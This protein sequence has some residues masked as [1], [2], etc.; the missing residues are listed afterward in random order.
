MLSLSEFIRDF[1]EA[2]S[3]M[4]HGY[5]IA[6]MTDVFDI[7]AVDKET[8][9]REDLYQKA[10]EIRMFNE[11]MEIKWFRSSV[12]KELQC[13]EIV[14]KENTPSF[15]WKGETKSLEYW[16][17]YQYLDIDDSRTRAEA[18]ENVVYATGGGSY[19]LPIAN[20]KD[21]KVKVR[22]YLSYETETNQAYI[23]DYR[24]VAFQ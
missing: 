1:N 13:R 11:Q 8:F 10:L 17:E 12:D 9:I 18:T 4:G 2:V 22:N 20:Y 15:T 24:F 16:D 7:Q 21:V 19:P 6:M 5:V 3:R 14:D 23:S